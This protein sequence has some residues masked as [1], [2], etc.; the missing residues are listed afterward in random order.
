LPVPSVGFS[1]GA[2]VAI[3]PMADHGP[4]SSYEPE[5][6]PYTKVAARRAVRMTIGQELRARYE[7][8]QDLSHELLT[9]LTRLRKQED[10]K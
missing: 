1:W 4:R 9:L 10:E 8:P 5:W 3:A 7:V 2:Q 6:L